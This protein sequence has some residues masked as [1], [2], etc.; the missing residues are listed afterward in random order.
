MFPDVFGIFVFAKQ[1][2]F[3]SLHFVECRAEAKR[4]RTNHEQSHLVTWCRSIVTAVNR[5]D[6]T[7]LKT[8]LKPAVEI[9]TA[10]GHPRT[11]M[12]QNGMTYSE[13]RWLVLQHFTFARH[14]IGLLLHAYLYPSN[15]HGGVGQI[16]PKTYAYA[17]ATNQERIWKRISS[18]D[19]LQAQ[20]AGFR[21]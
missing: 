15:H 20:Y 12:P 16:A 18:G 4:S 5:Y 8:Q 3:R 17:N 19:R 13:K 7:Q 1:L 21:R 14:G 6:K 9:P 2:T 10:S 11:R